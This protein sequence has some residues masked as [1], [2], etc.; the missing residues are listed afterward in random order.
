VAGQLQQRVISAGHPVRP[1][2]GHQAGVVGEAELAQ[3]VEGLR[4]QLPAR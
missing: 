3:Q 1:V 4:G 2:V